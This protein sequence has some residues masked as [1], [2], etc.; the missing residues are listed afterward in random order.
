[1]AKYTPLADMLGSLVS[2]RVTLRFEDID[3]LVGGLP[4]NARADRAWSGNTINRTRV[5]ARAWLGAVGRF[6]GVNLITEEAVFVR[7]SGARRP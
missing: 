5:Q 6:D 4:P 7:A 1:V 3:R 2:D